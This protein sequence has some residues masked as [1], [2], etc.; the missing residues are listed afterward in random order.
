MAIRVDYIS[1]PQLEDYSKETQAAQ[2]LVEM[3]RTCLSNYPNAKGYIKVFSN[4]S[5]FSHT[6]RDIDILIIGKFEKF[7]LNGDFCIPSLDGGQKVNKLE[8]DTFI[9]PIELKDHSKIQKNAVKGYVVE[10]NGKLKSVSS[11][12]YKQRFSLHNFLKEELGINA[13]VVDLLWF[14]NISVSELNKQR[15]NKIDNALAASFDF[16]DLIKAIVSNSQE[17]I[18]FYK[19]IHHINHLGD[20]FSNKSMIAIIKKFSERKEVKGLTRSKFELLSQSNVDVN[21]I[22]MY[23]VFRQRVC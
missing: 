15:E 18:K 4:I 10:Y 22:I 2:Q 23:P 6:I 19:D 11:Q 9:C 17:S 1:T 21:S 3:L 12:A 7:I 16:P 5:L 8:I 13:F 20:T 14:R